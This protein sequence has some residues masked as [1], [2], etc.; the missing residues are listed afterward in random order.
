MVSNTVLNTPWWTNVISHSRTDIAPHPQY[1]CGIP[2]YNYILLHINWISSLVLMASQ[3]YYYNPIGLHCTDDSYHNPEHSLMYW[4][5]IPS[6]V[7]MITP[8]IL[9]F[10]N[11]LMI[12]LTVLHILNSTDGIPP[13]LILAPTAFNGHSRGGCTCMTWQITSIKWWYLALR[14]WFVSTCTEW[15]NFLIAQICNILTRSKAF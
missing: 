1:W 6:N 5:W 8:T 10:S 12:S 9:M 4:T 11:V 7:L 3:Y 15:I 13:V 14:A 2:P